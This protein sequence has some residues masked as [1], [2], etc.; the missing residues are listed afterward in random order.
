MVTSL[1][2]LNDELDDVAGVTDNATGFAAN[3]ITLLEAAFRSTTTPFGNAAVRSVGTVSGRVPVLNTNG[4]L[5]D[6][7]IPNLNASKITAG[8][9][10]RKWQPSGSQPLSKITLSS[11]DPVAANLD[12]GELYLKYE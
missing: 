10:T 4:D 5:V 12:D 9:L 1:L 3:L 7:V 11:S 2:N 8:T 6:S